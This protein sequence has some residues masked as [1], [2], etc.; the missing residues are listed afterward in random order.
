[1]KVNLFHWSAVNPAL[2]IS[3]QAID[4]FGRWTTA[5]TMML[6]K[7]MTAFMTAINAVFAFLVLGAYV[8][9][10][11][12][13]TSDDILNVM[14]YIIITPLLTVTLTKIAYSGEQEMVVADALSRIDGILKIEPLESTGSAQPKDNSVVLYESILKG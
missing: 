2:C 3:K 10:K 11:G 8:F 9:T 12:S 4:G 6:R 13:V 7:P 14:Y 1:M 5:Y